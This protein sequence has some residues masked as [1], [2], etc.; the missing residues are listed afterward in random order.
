MNNRP[1]VSCIITTC[2][3]GPILN[4][5]IDSVLA[6]SYKNIECIVIDDCPCIETNDIMLSY[7]ENHNNVVHLSNPRN[8]GP[9]GARNKAVDHAK[10]EYIAFLDD[11]D[12]WH[13]SKIEKQ[14]FYAE[15]YSVVSCVPIICS[16]KSQKPQK[17]EFEG[18]TAVY[19]TNRLFKSTRHIFPSGMLMKKKH[20]LTVGG[21]NLDF[22]E[23][24]F[25]Y[26]MSKEIGDIIV[27]A[28][29][30]VYFDRTDDL[31]RVSKN[32][33]AYRRLLMVYL[34]YQNE[35]PKDI[36]NK[37]LAIL[38]KKRASLLK[39][40]ILL[41]VAMLLISFAYSTYN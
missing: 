11:D 2:K 8:L 6:Q 10:G 16:S 4:R 18:N 33:D 36:Y 31:E 12:Y 19:N 40:N 24:D 7:L 22:I 32:D 15:D 1:L 9:L 41:K 20:F 3:R 29:N 13:K 37:K 17:P 38:Y 34:K 35:I 28:E 25:F 5:A 26:K 39:S 30:L 14:M 27:L 23:H 21:F